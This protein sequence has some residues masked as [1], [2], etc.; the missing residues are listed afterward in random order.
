[1]LEEQLERDGVL[2][3]GE[4]IVIACSGG[5]DSVALVAALAA[6]AGPMRL[7][8]SI[9]HV[10]HGT[11][12]SAAQDECVALRVAAT[13]GLPIDIVALTGAERGE[14]ELRDARYAALGEIAQRRGAG[15]VATAH[16][17]QDQSET[18]LLALFRGAGPEG[19]RGMRSRRPLCAGVE[20]ARPLLR[21][22]PSRLR[23][24]CHA[25]ALP[26][27]VDPSNARATLRRNAVRQALE[28]L[29]PLFPGLDTAVAR[30][31]AVAHDD[32]TGAPRA[33]LRSRVREELAD[34]ASLRDVDFAHV[35]AAVRSIE[36]GSSGS[37][38]MRPG[39]RL[40]IERGEIAGIVEEP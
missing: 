13:F 6:V 18:V 3:A 19:L 8:T 37:F 17:A 33:A 7:E 11:R 35:E 5:A 22:D 38:L 25:H 30:A 36:R 10:N 27:A 15:A 14:Q 34:V 26:Y 31:A 39:L 23:D 29:R 32:L 24:Y 40:V 9:A 4:R 12:A 28:T 21:V 2:R 1:M 20:L 16:H